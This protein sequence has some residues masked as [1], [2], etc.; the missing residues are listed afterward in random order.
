MHERAQETT[1]NAEAWEDV[2]VVAAAVVAG[3][4]R[5]SDSGDGGEGSETVKRGQVAP[6]LYTV[7]AASC[8]PAPK[9]D[10]MR[11]VSCGLR[12]E[13]GFLFRVTLGPLKHSLCLGL[14]WF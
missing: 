11:S 6:C 7:S 13:S 12:S 9:R 4:S 14:R 1:R 10:E 5:S 2:P 3:P 8:S